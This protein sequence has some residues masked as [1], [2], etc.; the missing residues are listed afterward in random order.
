M[1][2]SSGTQLDQ[3]EDVPVG[4]LEIAR[5][6]TRNVLRLAESARAVALDQRSHVLQRADADAEHRTATVVA[7]P[8]ERGRVEDGVQGEVDAG[9]EL[10]LDP[11]GRGGPLGEADDVA[12]EAA[13]FLHVRYLQGHPGELVH[14]A[15]M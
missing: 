7:A 6:A 5:P 14:G 9:V 1:S 12:P 10:E 8:L 15:A 13:G 3:L 2:G 11:G 4:V